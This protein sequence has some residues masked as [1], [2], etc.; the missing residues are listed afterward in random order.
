VDAR[1]IVRDIVSCQTPREETPPVEEG[2]E[3]HDHSADAQTA[4]RLADIL[5]GV[6]VDTPLPVTVLSGFLG[7][8]KSTLLEHILHNRQNIRVALIV[9]DMSDLNIDAKLVKNSGAS[10]G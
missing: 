7:A 4:F 6:D 2:H 1:R 3:G 5:Q 10:R 9:N 8:G